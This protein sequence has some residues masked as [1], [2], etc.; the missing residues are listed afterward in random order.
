VARAE[1]AQSNTPEATVRVSLQQALSPEQ[2]AV[3]AR[4]IAD[5]LAEVSAASIPAVEVVFDHTGGDGSAARAEPAPSLVRGDFVQVGYLPY[6]PADEAEYLAWRRDVLMPIMSGAPG[7]V[8][9]VILRPRDGEHTFLVINK[10]RTRADRDAYM[11]S[12]AHKN[13]KRET[14]RVLGRDHPKP[15]DADVVHLY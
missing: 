4:L 11:Q 14:Q 8:S 3:A 7:F 9:S 1:S 2:Q 6:D 13:M 15:I 5:A 10:W 12:D